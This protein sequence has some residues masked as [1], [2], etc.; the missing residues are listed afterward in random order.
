MLAERYRK[1]CTLYFVQKSQ[2]KEPKWSFKGERKKNWLWRIR[3]IC[4]KQMCANK[5]RTSEIHLN[6]SNKFLCKQ[7]PLF[8]FSINN[9]FLKIY[10]IVNTKETEIVHMP[11]FIRTN[12]K[13][14]K[15]KKT[16]P[17]DSNAQLS[18]KR[19]FRMES[20]LHMKLQ[21]RLQSTDRTQRNLETV[22]IT[23][24][25]QKNVDILNL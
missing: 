16:S 3:N 7:L 20:T 13:H 4:A 14:G 17:D 23:G 2:F 12:G 6:T 21:C 22:Y 1:F 5:K 8:R 25:W 9:Q 11:K 15:A 24:F 19:G 10:K 18:S